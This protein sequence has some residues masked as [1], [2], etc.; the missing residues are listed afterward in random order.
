MVKIIKYIG[1]LLFFIA[2]LLFF[3]PKT[4]LYYL[5]QQEAK[6][7]EVNI[8]QEEVEQ[9]A[10]GLELQHITLEYKGIESAEIQKIESC[11]YLF[12]NDLNAY[13][14]ELSSL[15]EG[16]FPRK[17]KK[18]HMSYS[19]LQPLQINFYAEG[20]FGFA[21]GDLKLL[22]REFY[23]HLKPSALFLKEYKNSL[24]VLKKLENG[25]YSYEK[26]F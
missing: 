13:D 5:A 7:Y 9:K 18:L 22:N 26:S 4:N 19:L 3:L 12:Y 1:Y 25:E 16:Y 23:L 20:A 14:I 15:V 21:E 10:F 8:F 17:I 24:R 11:F 2:M 6:K